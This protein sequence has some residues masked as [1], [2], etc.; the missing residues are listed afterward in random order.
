VHLQIVHGLP[1]FSLLQIPL[2]SRLKRVV[3]TF[4]DP[5]VFSGHCIYPLDCELWRMGCPKC[6]DLALP[7]A[8]SRD[9]SALNWKIKRFVLRHT[10]G[11]IVVASA[12]MQRRVEESGIAPHLRCVVIPLGVDTAV[13]RP[14]DRDE[15][16]RALGIE[17]DAH[18][19]AFRDAGT[20]ERFKNAQLVVEALKRYAPTRKTYVLCFQ[21]SDHARQL[22]GSYEVI[23]LGWVPTGEEA[24]R[25]YT[26]ADLFLMPS[27]AEAF[28]MMAVEAMACG[29]PVI[30][31]DGTALPDV[32]QA[33]GIGI[34]VP[35]GD[36][37]ALARSIG[38][39]LADPD[40][41]QRRGAAG[42]DLVER[43]YTFERYLEDH[44]RLYTESAP[45]R[46]RWGFARKRS[47]VG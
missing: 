13:F 44:L 35:Q 18:V 33:P 27:R 12:W 40:D 2:L 46:R 10:R 38:A 9:N 24:A 21:T 43:R 32:V 37:E 42:R 39:L 3:W 15:S 25:A 26:A 34:S 31:A 36:P 5:W 16:R 4:H 11:T 20:G 30:V 47:A 19:V 1:G 45:R 22:A 29:I 41:R 6:P 8:V 23:D 7:I 14:R 17:P 28:G